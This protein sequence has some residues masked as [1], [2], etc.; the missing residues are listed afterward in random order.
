MEKFKLLSTRKL[1][2]VISERLSDI[3]DLTELDFISVSPLLEA[4]RKEKI[5]NLA[6]QEIAVAFTSVHAV[7]IVDEVLKEGKVNADWKIF[8]LSGRTREAVRNSLQIKNKIEGEGDNAFSLAEKILEAKLKEIFFFCGNQRRDELPSLLQQN[9]VSVKEIIVYETSERPIAVK[10]EFDGI[11][12]FSPSAAR[13]FFSANLLKPSV[14]CFAVGKT[15]ATS[16]STYTGNRILV[17][18]TP[19]QEKI[20]ELVRNFIHPTL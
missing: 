15:T 14:V 16:I 4:D 7:E 12:F 18:E 11:L 1:N 17:S 8:C 13:S 9:N 10:K 20:L 2:S 3:A 5:R 6:E 19:S